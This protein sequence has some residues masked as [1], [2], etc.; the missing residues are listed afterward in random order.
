MGKVGATP[1]SCNNRKWGRWDFTVAVI[2]VFVLEIEIQDNNI[3][4]D[5]QDR[6]IQ[7]IYF[8]LK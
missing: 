2:I 7:S 6:E 5:G 4:K 1:T 8:I 3:V